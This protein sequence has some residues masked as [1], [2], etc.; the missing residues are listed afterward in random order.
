MENLYK[1]IRDIVAVEVLEDLKKKYI[2]ETHSGDVFNYD[3][4]GTVTEFYRSLIH[5]TDLKII[6]LKKSIDRRKLIMSKGEVE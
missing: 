4:D 1:F 5:L 3:Y 6:E 2:Q